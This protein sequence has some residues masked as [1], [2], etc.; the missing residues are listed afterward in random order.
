MPD[1]FIPNGTRVALRDKRHGEI[2]GTWERRDPFGEQWGL[3]AS[4]R[5][6]G[7]LVK[8]DS[9]RLL[10]VVPELFTVVIGG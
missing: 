2:M 1:L 6:T 5:T 7:Y 10:R 8:L 3:N 9:G 4:A